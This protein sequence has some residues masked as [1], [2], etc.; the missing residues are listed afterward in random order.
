MD[1]KS[2]KLPLKTPISTAKNQS[3]PQKATTSPTKLTSTSKNPQTIS[4]TLKNPTHNSPKLGKPKQQISPTKLPISKE[5]QTDSSEDDI[6]EDLSIENKIKQ[7]SPTKYFAKRTSFDYQKLKSIEKPMRRAS[8]IEGLNNLKI[9]TNVDK[10]LLVKFSTITEEIKNEEKIE[11]KNA[12]KNE[13]PRRSILK[14][15]Y[16]EEEIVLTKVFDK[17][18]LNDLIEKINK[19]CGGDQKLYNEILPKIFLEFWRNNENNPKKSL[20]ILK[21]T[22]SF[23]KNSI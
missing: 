14:N 5:I 20:L 9:S 10:G 12:F 13:K 21:V 3:S 11:S 1:K 2:S 19:A 16:I 4:P 8:A 22:H 17:N 18:S 6:I 15:T 7:L 23:K